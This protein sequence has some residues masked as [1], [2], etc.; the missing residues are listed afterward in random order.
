ML[1][2]FLCPLII[3]YYPTVLV[4]GIGG[5]AND[6]LQVSNAL[7]S[8][9]LDVYP[10][11]I[12]NGKIDSIIWNANKQCAS[13]N[14]SIAKLN[15]SREK[16]NIIGISQGGLLARCYVEKYS[17]LNKAVNSLITYGTP[18]M[19]IYIQ[20]ISL[21]YFSYWNDPFHH[22]KYLEDNQ[23]LVYINNEKEHINQDLYKSN[24]LSLNHF[25]IV[26]S[27][28]DNVISPTASSRFEFYNISLAEE[29]KELEIVPLAKNYNYINDI[30][31]LKTLVEKNVMSIVQ[32]PCL[33]DEFK[34]PNCFQQIFP[35][36]SIP[37]I[38]LTLTIL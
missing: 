4:H 18:H 16:I 20:G 37:L 12:G 3:S 1:F 38:N 21:S 24:L 13:L 35:N 32:Y 34:D 31:G 33:H 15:I 8:Q 5:N 17:H 11:Q 10:I 27:K 30:L 28:L 22:K 25:L 7:T 29:R 36:I 23:F 19:G 2:T 26:W 14:I 6:L 9:G